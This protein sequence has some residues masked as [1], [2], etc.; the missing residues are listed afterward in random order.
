[1]APKYLVAFKK[2]IQEF[3][4]NLDYHRQGEF[5][6]TYEKIYSNF[7]L[8][9]FQRH[10]YNVYNISVPI[11]FFQKYLHY[12]GYT[13]TKEPKLNELLEEL[14]R[15]YDLAVL[16][17]WFRCSQYERLKTAGIAQYFKEVVGGDEYIKPNPN[18]YLM[19]KGTYEA[20]ECVM[21][22]DSYETDIKGA[23][24]V[25][26]KGILI[27]SDDRMYNV[28]TIK[29]VYEIKRVLRKGEIYGK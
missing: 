6:S 21:I 18:S 2:V 10:F 11:E 28:P 25:G 1:M 26:M 14:T 20:E 22:G 24:D 13:S 23:L 12:L 29:N 8:E 19:V 27:S 16:T 5:A 15:D 3:N 7:N 9:D 17:N 4:I